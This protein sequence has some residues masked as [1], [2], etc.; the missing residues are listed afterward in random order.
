MQRYRS[1]NWKKL[2]LGRQSRKLAADRR[3][4]HPLAHIDP[5]KCYEWMRADCA[6]SHLARQAREDGLIAT[7][8][9]ISSAALLGIPGLLFGSDESLP[10]VNQQPWLYIG[11]S[12]F[13]ITLLLALVEQYLSGKAYNR[14][15]E[16]A[17]QY[18][19]RQSDRTSD[20]A[21]VAWVRKC[22]N[23]ALVTFGAAVIISTTALMTL[24]RKTDGKASIAA[25]ASPSAAPA[26]P[27]SAPSTSNSSRSGAGQPG[28]SAIGS[29]VDPAAPKK[30]VDNDGR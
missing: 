24:E 21:F 4:A 20:S 25:P 18:Y 6:A 11:I 5:D 9:Q 17:Q 7:V 30:T 22:R 26:A 28:N 2:S 23:T 14:Q 12:L 13:L 16:I 15:V 3:G 29:G 19:L 1:D 27:A 8:T 10:Q